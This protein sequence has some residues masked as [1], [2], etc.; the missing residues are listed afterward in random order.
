MKELMAVYWKVVRNVAVLRIRSVL[1]DTGTRKIFNTQ[2]N[3]LRIQTNSDTRGQGSLSIL[4][5]N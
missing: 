3:V 5:E 4:N 2:K 1:A